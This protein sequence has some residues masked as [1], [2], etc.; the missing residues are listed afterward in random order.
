MKRTVTASERRFFQRARVC[1]IGSVGR[2]GRPHV[3][4]FCHALDQRTV[5]VA[6]DRDGRTAENLRRRPRATIACDDYFEDWNR[7]RGVVVQARARRVARGAEL[8]RA[9]RLLTKKYSQYSDEDID[10]V[11]ALRIERATSWGI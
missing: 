11:I 4:P 10:Y 6:T 3:T 8:D 9:R 2:D 7:L 5:Y 1:R